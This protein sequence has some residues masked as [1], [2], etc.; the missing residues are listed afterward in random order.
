[1]NFAPPVPGLAANAMMGDREAV[2]EA[3]MERTD[4]QADRRG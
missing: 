1:M 3:G 4:C 2:L